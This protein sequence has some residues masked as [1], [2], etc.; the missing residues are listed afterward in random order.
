MS[1]VLASQLFY[2]SYQPSLPTSLS[3][4]IA[5]ARRCSRQTPVAVMGTYTGKHKIRTGLFMEQARRTEQLIKST[6]LPR[7]TVPLWMS[8]FHTV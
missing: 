7:T 4:I 1:L 3:Y 8:Q 5:L 6:A 2:R